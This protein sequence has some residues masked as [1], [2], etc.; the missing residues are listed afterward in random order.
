MFKR[1]RKYGLNF[2]TSD[3]EL[4]ANEKVAIKCI[5]VMTSDFCVLLIW[6]SPG[7]WYISRL[8]CIFLLYLPMIDWP[9]YQ[10]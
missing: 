1:I 2:V 10:Q 5:L 9:V 8:V 3:E 4:Y 6:I 7:N